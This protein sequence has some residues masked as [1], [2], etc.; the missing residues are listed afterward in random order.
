MQDMKVRL[1][2]ADDAGTIGR[3]LWRWT[4]ERDQ[5]TQSEEAY[6]VEFRSWCEAHRA[7]H[8]PFLAVQDDGTAV[9]MA[10]LALLDRVPRPI[11]PSRV[12]GDVQSVYVAPEHRS[13]GIGAALMRALLE[14]AKD[15]GLE[16]VTVHSG[17]RAV[18][19]YERAG[20]ADTSTMLHLRTPD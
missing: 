19:V 15:L 13:N 11:T 12:C 20:F 1:A 5:P 17:T 9:G 18:H 8:I 4:Q 7:T 3:M 14:H 16:H 10:W 6:A 2:S